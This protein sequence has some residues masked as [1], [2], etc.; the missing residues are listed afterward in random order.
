M[1]RLNL[2]LVW[3]KQFTEF[4]EASQFR[5]NCWREFTSS[6]MKWSDFLSSGHCCSVQHMSIPHC[7]ELQKVKLRKKMF[8]LLLQKLYEFFEY[9]VPLRVRELSY[10][11]SQL[12]Q[13]ESKTFTLHNVHLGLVERNP[14]LSRTV[15]EVWKT[16]ISRWEVCWM[17]C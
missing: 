2:Q 4:Q 17:T 13:T 5:R 1:N 15:E 10:C 7:Y 11:W 14:Q 3:A 9:R 12:F 8:V 6:H 16:F